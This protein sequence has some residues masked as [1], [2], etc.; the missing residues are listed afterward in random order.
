MK[1]WNLINLCTPVCG[2]LFNNQWASDYWLFDWSLSQKERATTII[3]WALGRYLP[4]M[5]NVIASA[6]K[7]LFINKRL[8]VVQRITTNGIKELNFI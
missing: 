1:N 5:G 7:Q 2:L 8:F 6:R 4:Q 3:V